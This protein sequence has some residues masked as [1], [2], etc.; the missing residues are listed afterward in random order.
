MYNPYINVKLCKGY[1]GRMIIYVNSK[2]KPRRKS[3]K[4][5]LIVRT[6][7]KTKFVPIS[8]QFNPVASGVLI[9]ETPHYP[10][11]KTESSGSTTKPNHPPT[12]TGDKM[13]G[14]GTLHKSNGVPLFRQE[15]LEDQ[16]KMRR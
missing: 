1:T 16:A 2:F 7:A 11:L 14:V 6:A 3:K 10:S 12:Y 9:R 5:N 8:T 13:I 4:R 15:D